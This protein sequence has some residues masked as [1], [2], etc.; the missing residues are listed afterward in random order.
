M[1]MEALITVLI[2]KNFDDCPSDE[3]VVVG[4]R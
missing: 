1:S 2:P 4:G 3:M